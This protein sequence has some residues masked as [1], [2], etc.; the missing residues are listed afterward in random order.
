MH[1]VGT[2]HILSQ[3]QKLLLRKSQRT[4]EFAA[5]I[6]AHD[7]HSQ[8]LN[9]LIRDISDHGAQIRVNAAQPVP[10]PCYMINLRTGSG[11]EAHAVWRH[12]SLTGLR[13]GKEYAITDSLPAHLEFLRSL[14]R[15]AKLRQVDQLISDGAEIMAALRR[16]GVTED[17]YH[18]GCAILLH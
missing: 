10:E 12:G 13:L 15:E 8:P 11:Y 9:C 17:F 4:H 18:H 3:E 14:F 6:L 7:D 1:K 2:A 16:C 5:G